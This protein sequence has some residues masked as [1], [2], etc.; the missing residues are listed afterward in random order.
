MVTSAP[1]KGAQPIASA[2]SFR[3]SSADKSPLFDEHIRQALAMRA[4]SLDNFQKRGL[5]EIGR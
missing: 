2:Q 1:S 3:A 4:S 5:I